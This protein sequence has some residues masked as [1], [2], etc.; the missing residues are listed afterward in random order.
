MSV[1]LDPF[2]S[3]I[4]RCISL[5]QKLCEDLAEHSGKVLE[6]EVELPALNVFVFFNESSVRLSFVNDNAGVASD[7]Q[8]STGSGPDGKISG[9]ASAL[10]G[11]LL[12]PDSN[13]P[14]V[15]RNI[16]VS[17]DSEFIQE[18][19]LLFTN[20]DIDWQEPLS[21][22][23]GDIPTHGIDQLFSKLRAFT[24]DST[25]VVSENIDEYLHEEIRLVPPLNQVEMFD[26]DLDKLKLRLDRLNARLK[27][28]KNVLNERDSRKHD[29]A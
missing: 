16:S 28:A 25:R 7:S 9:S 13:R 21:K 23:I 5:D 22:L 11:V 6:I 20:M 29:P 12:T 15:N 19:Q 17:G 2:E 14:L 4:N 3:L 8:V 10:L 1:L 18:I 27:S 24:R 26:Q